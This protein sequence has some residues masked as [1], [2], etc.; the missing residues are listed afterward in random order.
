MLRLLARVRWPDFAPAAA[1]V[2]TIYAIG[3]LSTFWLL[4]RLQIAFTTA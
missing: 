3:G 2:A 1:R 4:D